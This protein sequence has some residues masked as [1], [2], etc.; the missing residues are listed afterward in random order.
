ML[1]FIFATLLLLVRSNEDP[2][3]LV[4]TTDNFDE[5]IANNEFVLVEFY[6]PWCGHC[7]Q[8]APEYSAAAT[9]LKIKGSPI[10]LAKVDA[11]VETSLGEKFGVR[12]YPTIKFFRSG[13]PTEYDAGRT[14]QD[15]IN[16]VTKKSGPPSKHLTT[17]EEVSAYILGTGTRGLY[18]GTQNQDVWEATAKNE[19][20]SAFAFA[21]VTDTALFA[22]RREGTVEL[23]KDGEPLPLEYT[24]AFEADALVNW[25]ATEGFPIVDDLSQDSWTRAQS[26]QTDLLAVFFNEG[27]EARAAAFAVAKANKGKLV[28]TSSSQVGIATRWGSSGSVLPTAVYVSNKVE[29]APSFTVWNEETEGPLNAASLAEFVSASAAGSYNSYI[30]SEPIPEDNSGP[31]TIVVGKNFD[32]IVRSN[33]DVLIEFYAP[34]CGHCKQLEPI[35]NELGAFFA[36]DRHLLIA[37]MDATANGTPKDVDVRGFP[38]ILF[39]DANNKVQTYEGERDLEAFKT[40]LAANRVTEAAEKVD[41]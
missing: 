8:L 41:L 25:Y 6:A 36:K 9:S 19:K 22:G 16:W 7:K 21:H 30:K 29:G 31:V 24:D 3:V 15:I 38:T 37:K 40:W 34:W 13:N 20:T 14:S 10:K 39:F 28:V 32:E 2:D 33:K 5:V 27:D 26:S 23:H 18:F 11:T 4:L 12:G 35:Y 1:A 17:P